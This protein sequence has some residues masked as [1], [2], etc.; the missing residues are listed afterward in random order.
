MGKVSEW[1]WRFLAAVMLFAVGWALWIFY[2]IN[3]AP[4]ATGAAF[5]AAAKA[6]A[7]QSASGRIAPAARPPE[8][9]EAP[10][11]VEKLKLSDTI[12]APQPEGAQTK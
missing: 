1:F 7:A 2:Q 4:L 3:P 10:V 9:R 12:T 5:E 11:N 6:R 8:T